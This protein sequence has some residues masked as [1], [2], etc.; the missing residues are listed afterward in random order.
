M[1]GAERA[2]GTALLTA[3][4]AAYTGY[5]QSQAGKA[6][7]KLMRAETDEEARRLEKQQEENLS[8]GK[9]RAAASGVAGKP[10]GSQTQFLENVQKEQGI[11]LAWLKKAGA[12]RAGMAGKAGT[13]AGVSTFGS[14]I[15]SAGQQ[16]G[17]WYSTSPKTA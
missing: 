1:T 15:A 9:A 6:N 16:Y 11:Q 14:G 5:Q 8:E 3:G 17:D 2:L 4:T 7:E 10:G 13:A 12:S